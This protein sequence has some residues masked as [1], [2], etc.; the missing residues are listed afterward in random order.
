MATPKFSPKAYSNVSGTPTT[1]LAVSL[2]VLHT[3][4]FDPIKKS[5][6]PLPPHAWG[7]YH[8]ASKKFLSVGQCNDKTGVCTIMKP[9]DL[10]AGSYSLQVFPLADATQQ[11]YVTNKEAWIDLDTGDWL[12]PTLVPA[13]G[14]PALLKNKILRIP[15][16]TTDLKAKSGGGFK[17]AP[18]KSKDAFGKNGLLKS[19]DIEPYGSAATPW[20]MPLDFGWIRSHVAYLF[21]NW[22]TAKEETSAPPGLLVE[23][24]DA[25]GKRLGAGG[26]VDPDDGTAYVLVAAT[27]DKWKGLHVGFAL[28]A[29][30]R[31][32]ISADPKPSPDTRLT[33]D[34]AVPD[35]RN[36]RVT[37]P[38]AWHSLGQNAFYAP[39]PGGTATAPKTWDDLRKDLSKD[40][41]ATEPVLTFHLNDVALVRAGKLVNIP[42]DSRLTLFD[43]LLTIQNPD[44][45]MP[46]LTTGKFSSP[47][48]PAKTV[49]A[50][51][52]ATPPTDPTV[53][54]D[55]GTRLVNYQGS[56]FDLEESFVSGTVGTTKLLGARAAVAG[57]HPIALYTAGCKYVDGQGRYELHLVPVPFVKDPV[58]K[59][60]LFHGLV[61]IGSKVIGQKD[62]GAGGKPYSANV[63]SNFYTLLTQAAVR[64]S[65]GHPGVANA[66][67]TQKDYRITSEDP[68]NG[69]IIRLRFFFNERSDNK[70]T[71]IIA[72]TVDKA[73]N[74]RSRSF[75]DGSGSQMTYYDS[76]VN[77]DATPG[78]NVQDLDNAP[79]YWH[80]L[81]HEFGHVLGLPDE[82]YEHLPPPDKTIQP[83]APALPGYDQY[84][85]WK[86]GARPYCQDS[87]AQMRGNRLLRLR[88]VWHHVRA[89]NDDAQFKSL[90]GRPYTV[91]NLS[92]PGGGL[93]YKTPAGKPGK[94]GKVPAAN[95]NNPYTPIRDKMPLADL[96]LFGVGED[97]STVETMFSPA[98]GP[99]ARAAGTRF[100]GILVVRTYYRF[101]FP[102][103]MA[104]LD[105]WNC[106]TG[107]H[108]GYYDAN[109]AEAFRFQLTGGT[110]LK[111]IAVAFAPHYAAGGGGP[112]AHLRINVKGATAVDAAK[113]PLLKDTPGTTLGLGTPDITPIPILRL[114][115][116]GQS[117]TA[118][119]GP[120]RTVDASAIT[121]AD[122]TKLAAAV[123]K[124]LGDAAG[125]R[126]AAPI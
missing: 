98:A 55:L 107:F 116:G 9:K 48:L 72:L 16:W 88:H 20:E 93:T 68:G 19:T 38:K 77:G 64:W 122:L 94:D 30:A 69:S 106:M 12:D 2:Y 36:T 21:I 42:K 10:T 29:A 37:L 65:Q 39:T 110:V 90:K 8:T 1:T 111:T 92:Y 23:V 70:Q 60:D 25:T 119:P 31:I 17:D 125:T 62:V 113:N 34:G 50:V 117:W 27:P 24:T 11:P 124:M 46:H 44:A 126:V 18:P 6:Q 52:P 45:Q 41:S 73:K 102:A 112:P 103:A 115:L 82:Y 3:T 4:Y 56:F 85:G 15:V 5:D 100:D 84:D 74:D 86:S 78:A 63:V 81:A 49:Y 83:T 33:A 32:D 53:N 7:L 120:A 14:T 96:I 87:Y 28:P 13:A 109:Y 40:G 97:E 80:T 89:F 91:E 101:V 114:V 66:G 58:T 95:I 121:I 123:D 35:D 43:H 75:V 105:R 76:A 108:G 99:V 47:V 79:G 118:N 57:A 61:Y 71:F 26:A 51:D 54:R 22:K 104:K 59:L 67:L